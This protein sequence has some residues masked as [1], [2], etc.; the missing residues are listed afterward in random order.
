MHTILALDEAAIP[1][2]ARLLALHKTS[3]PP[4]P[5][6]AR[7]VG[8]FLQ[9]ADD[10]LLTE[11][12]ELLD[13]VDLDQHSDRLQ[14]SLHTRSSDERTLLLKSI[15]HSQSLPW[16][17]GGEVL[18]LLLLLRSVGLA[19]EPAGGFVD[20]MT[21]PYGASLSLRRAVLLSRVV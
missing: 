17:R 11:A 12:R 18:E 10:A 20:M 4:R 21:G 9:R 16:T 3:T 19:G 15:A 1:A 6:D 13:A 7:L 14:V 8:E 2:I 5:T